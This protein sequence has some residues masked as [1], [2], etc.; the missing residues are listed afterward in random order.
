MFSIR[1]NGKFDKTERYLKKLRGKDFTRILSKYG[2]Q[3]VQALSESTPIDSG[4]TARS[5]G[6]IIEHESDGQVS[7]AW[8]N[9]HFNKGVL[10]YHHSY[11]MIKN[12][13]LRLPLLL[14]PLLAQLSV[15]Q[16]YLIELLKKHGRR[17]IV[18]A[19]D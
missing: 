1:S 15:E 7:I 11:R 3:G 18:N 14:Q 17:S 8:T 10:L 16:L 2:E 6:Y 19:D 12:R 5:W 9:S 4:E 13:I